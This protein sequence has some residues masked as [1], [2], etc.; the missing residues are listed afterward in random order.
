MKVRNTLQILT[1]FDLWCLSTTEFFHKSSLC[2][3]LNNHLNLMSAIS[4]GE[5]LSTAMIES[6]LLNLVFFKNQN[7]TV[8]CLP[9]NSGRFLLVHFAEVRCVYI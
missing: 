2:R 4:K 8:T 5:N 3:P 6:K 1:D 7:V 9:V